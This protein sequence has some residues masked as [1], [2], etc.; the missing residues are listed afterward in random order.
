MKK[1]ILSALL[2][3]ISVSLTAQVKVASPMSG[4]YGANSKLFSKAP[5]DKIVMA[6]VNNW[7]NTYTFH[8]IPKGYSVD[9]VGAV[10]DGL[11]ESL[12]LEISNAC[13]QQMQSAFKEAGIEIITLDPEKIKANKMYNKGTKSGGT[14]S[15]GLAAA[16]KGQNVKDESYMAAVPNGVNAVYLGTNPMANYSQFHDQV[17]EDIDAVNANYLPYFSFTE[18]SST[19]GSDGIAFNFAPK[20]SLRHG[21]KYGLSIFEYVSG[22][23]ANYNITMPEIV[24]EKND[25]LEEKTYDKGSWLFHFK[26]NP[27]N[28][29]KAILEMNAVCVKQYVEEFK[30]ALAN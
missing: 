4:S 20:L 15:N 12:A 29:K 28:F 1:L 13:Y 7:I 17:T 11:T 16:V 26:I 6:N 5:K 24:Y 21:M 30:K 19:G 10:M 23:Y 18:Y 22:K 25:W 9:Y 14:I 27:E 8:D 3:L 2:P